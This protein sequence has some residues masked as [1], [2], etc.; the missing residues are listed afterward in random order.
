[1]PAVSETITTT[2]TELPESRAR[3]EVQVSPKEVER[4]MA[5]T[6]QR[7]AKDMRMPGFR[8]GKVPP[9]VVIRQLGR[10]A[11][12]DETVRGQLGR[13]Y[14]D[15]IESAGLITVGDPDLDLG[16]LPG[17]GEPLAFHFEIGV[18]PTA[19]LGEYTGVKVGRR[20]PEPDDEKVEAEITRLRERMARLETKDDAAGQGDY[21][22]MDY[23][24]SIDGEEFEGGAGR[25]QLLELGSSTLIPGFE[26]QLQGTKAGDEVTVNVTFP[27]D[28]NAEHLAGKDAQFAVTV[29][30]VKEKRLP[31]LDDEF[32]SDAAGF[33]TL[34]ELRA[35]IAEKLTE[36]QTTQIEGEF[37]EAVVDAAVANATVEL[38]DAL[39]EARAKELWERMIHSLGHQGIN[40]EMYLQITG[41]AEEEIIDEAK[42]D[43]AQALRREAVLAAVVEAESIEPAD[44]DLLEALQAS[45]VR[46]N[47]T[48]EKLRDKLE[49]NGRIDELKTDL[50][51]R[52][53][54][55]LLAEHAQAI[56]V[57]DA[58]KGSLLWT[59][60]PAEVEAEGSKAGGRGE[61]WTPSS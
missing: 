58:K 50:A 19:T 34:D 45:A 20:E 26:E 47:T 14:L 25:E 56:I 13:W 37:R 27:E 9:P 46:E 52:M 44:G 33:D 35:D 60:D 41:R 43:A 36:Q 29:K 15:A 30:E 59:P 49:K 28:Y 8:K 2:V 23:V 57:E 51:Q 16:D 12:L 38:P 3:V 54:V 7:L 61:L 18:R 55:D 42:P 53:A 39:V 21:V 1:M 32:A 24:G 40:K 11:V 10:E 22:V 4:R 31:D 17:Q 48:P 5:E 6:A